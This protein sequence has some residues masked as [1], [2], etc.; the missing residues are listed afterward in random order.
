MLYDPEDVSNGVLI[1]SMPGYVEVHH[2][3]FDSAQGWRGLWVLI[4]PAAACVAM[5]YAVMP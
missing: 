4:A 2:G 1:D 3:G 5:V